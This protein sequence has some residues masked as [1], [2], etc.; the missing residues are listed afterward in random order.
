[1]ATINDSLS[2]KISQGLSDAV[3]KVTNSREEHYKNNPVPTIDSIGI[4]IQSYSNKNAAISGGAGIIPGPLGMA[5]AVPE[6]MLVTKNQIEMIYDI[7]K[8]HGQNPEKITNELII[9]IL[10][11]AM[12]QGATA[13]FIVQGQKVM[14]KRVGA[15]AL[16]NLIK[17][18][19]GK[20]TQQAAKS[21]AAKWVPVAG[22]IAMASWSKYSTTKIGANAI[23]IFSKEIE[24]VEFEV[25][26]DTL[27]DNVTDTIE[28]LDSIN[29]TKIE[30]LIN[31]M[32]IDGKI[33]DKEI[34]FIENFIKKTDLSSEDKMDLIGKIGDSAKIKIDYTPFKEDKEE[35]LHLLIDLISLAKADGQFHI[36]EKMFIKEIAKILEFSA[37]DIIELMD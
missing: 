20:I 37:T 35:G 15:R 7:A 13:L 8:A 28:N 31:L 19:G 4:I 22:A 36:T 29:K 6:I 30:V 1:M 9:G 34:E 32:K 3:I 14:A 25:S 16:Q 23:E 11:G 10:F 18:L 24:I 21:M 27:S 5:A 33:D 17:I 2:D 26:E 12:G